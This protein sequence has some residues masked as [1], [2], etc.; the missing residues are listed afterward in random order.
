MVK[1]IWADPVWS[2]VISVGIIGLISVAYTKFISVTENISYNEA[3]KKII[4]IKISVFYVLIAIL[5]YLILNWLVK[6]LL[7]KEKGIYTL[8][9]EQLRIYNK[10]TDVKTGILFKWCVSFD[11]ETPFIT[12]LTPFCTKHGETPIRFLGECCPME[13]CKNSRGIDKYVVKNLIESDLIDRWEK[14]KT[15]CN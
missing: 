5:I 9:Q 10:T 7:K 8:K 6:K 3:V 13:G 11:N 15:A 4:E 14:I 2:K 1:K 12:E